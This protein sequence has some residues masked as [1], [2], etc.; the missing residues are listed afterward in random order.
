MIAFVDPLLRPQEPCDLKATS[1]QYLVAI[2]IRAIA[3]T[4]RNPKPVYATQVGAG[5]FV[6]SL[7]T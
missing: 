3:A 2:E 5:E 6:A 1:L 7:V 4:K